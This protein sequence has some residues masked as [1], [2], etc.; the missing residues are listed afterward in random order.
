MSRNAN[1]IATETL[2]RKVKILDGFDQTL[3]NDADVLGA[4]GYMLRGI[5]TVGNELLCVYQRTR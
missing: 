1:S 4:Q 2:V 3:R 5:T